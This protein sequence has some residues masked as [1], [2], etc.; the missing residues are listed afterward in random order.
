MILSSSLS[1]GQATG[2]IL[3]SVTDASSAR[4]PGV[5]VT[6][7]NPASGAQRTAVTNE[8]GAY[9]FSSL[10]PGDYE[11]TA[12]MAGFR[13]VLKRAT[14]NVGRSVTVDL[15]MEVGEVAQAIDVVGEASAIN[16]ENSRVDAIVNQDQIN[17]LPLNG[18]SA[19][20]MAKLVPGVY[21]RQRAQGNSD[22]QLYIGGHG[23]GDTRY[24]VDGIATP[25]F[26][27]GGL[28]L[29][30]SQDAVQEF[31][32]SLS[33]NDPSIGISSGGAINLVSRA[34]TNAFHGTFSSFFREGVFGAFPG[35]SHP[36][37]KPNPNNDPAIAE[38][39][40]VQANPP[41]YRRQYAVTL[42]GPLK[43]DKLFWL[44]SFD[45]QRGVTAAVFDTNNNELTAFNRIASYPRDRFMQN[46]RMD[47]HATNNHSFFARL[48]R[49][50]FYTR[51]PGLS[52][53]ISAYGSN[54]VY[55]NQATQSEVLAWTAVWSPT[56]V[57]DFRFGLSKIPDVGYGVK[58]SEEEAKLY[59][60]SLPRMGQVVVSGVNL[61]FGSE[62]GQPRNISGTQPQLVS[63]FTYLHG[64][65]TWKF[66]ANYS[67]VYFWM[68]QDFDN[69]FS[70]TVFN[71]TQARQAGIPIPATF[72]TIGDLLQ[73]PLA[74]IRVAVQS[75]RFKHFPE[76][77]AKG[78]DLTWN[79]QLYAYVGDTLKATPRLTMNFSLSYMYDPL[80]TPNWDLPRPSSMAPLL[81][82]GNVKPKG[83]KKD[84]F[85]PT[86]GFAWDPKGTGKTVIR[87]GYGL[88]WATGNAAAGQ[89]ERSLIA[90]L[91]NGYISVPANSL[92]NPKTGRGSLSFGSATANANAGIFR[93]SDFLSYVA[94]IRDQL[95][96]TIFNGTNQDFSVTNFDFFKGSSTAM[97]D[98]NN[99]NQ[100]S[101]QAMA[102]VQ[103]QFGAD[104]LVDATTLYNVTNHTPITY[105]LNRQFRP[106]SNGGPILPA[107]GNISVLKAN[108][109][110]VYKALF[111]S[112]RKRLSHH[113]Q[114]GL[115][116]TWSSNRTTTFVDYDNWR[117]NVGYDPFSFRHLLNAHFTADLPWGFQVAFISNFQSKPPL[118]VFLNGIDL[119]GDGTANDVL[120]GLTPNG[121]N[122]NNSKEDT[123][124]AVAAFNTSYEG[125]RDARGTVIREIVLP[126]QWNTGDTSITQDMRLTKTIDIK[127]H[128]KVSLIAEVFNLF[129]IAN[130][131][132]AASAGNVYSTGF[133]QPNGRLG[134][135]FGSEGPRA[136]QFAARVNF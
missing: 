97:Y 2:S 95:Q 7:V 88:Y 93:M 133:G 96:S 121:V 102:G 28:G 81:A 105:D 33:N 35:L 47:W 68:R 23:P 16:L 49:D 18:R 103:R 86:F 31:Q 117:N 13:T 79:Q 72:T 130:L 54:D 63:N 60:P 111:V 76:V 106:A 9:N 110:A 128:F 43:K 50:S 65:N 45:V 57:S 108:G 62:Q 11:V 123:I 3:G 112:M 98:P 36:T 8:T 4:M 129:N 21:V 38:F 6:A 44:A 82:N 115:S 104:W 66:G 126:A 27:R 67:P 73:L 52:T 116:Y 89:R 100:Y 40:D 74:D 53:M 34:G 24:S 5:T 1:F 26:F 118:N 132:Y 120:P 94:Q 136:F 80:A 127:E 109:K 125:K 107:F 124:K 51:T 14:V 71:P 37:P 75:P 20:E 29:N 59:V 48:S 12:E 32:V 135:L 46:Y 99:K 56:L 101:L 41:L 10:L 85:A 91:G 25:D 119:N 83:I 87:G 122:A 78:Q 64:R 70:G 90:P 61:Q 84:Q 114:A 134:Y 69:P 55:R 92:T 77:F 42:S 19:F 113:Y 58:E 17:D 30:L 15:A 22:N 131:A 39:N